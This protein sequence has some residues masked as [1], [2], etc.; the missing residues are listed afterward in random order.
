MRA[1]GYV[2][3]STEEQARYGISLDAQRAKIRAYA[4]LED[5]ELIGIEADEGISGCS[6]KARPG[7]QRVLEFVRSR[8][9][10][11]VVIQKLD[12]LSR[13]TSE[14]LA[15]SNMFDKR[16]VA[17]H[18]ISEKLDTTSAT[19]RFFFTLLASLAEMERG[20]ISERICAAM[21]R[22][23]QIGTPCNGNPPF[24]YRIVDWRVVPNPDEQAIINRVYELREQG[25][26]IHG[27]CGTLNAEGYVNRKGKPLAATQVHS[28]ITRKAS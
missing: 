7:V 21:E 11:A 4:E 1:I 20:I 13:S 28:L 16:G 23:R 14:S 9:V 25:L 27:I 24:G 15:L 5:M 18:S 3:V 6:V 2:R 10:D 8:A 12:R 26:P 19:G 17:L 22:K